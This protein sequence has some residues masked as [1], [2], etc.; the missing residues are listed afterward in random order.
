[1]VYC[2]LYSNWFLAPLTLY[3]KVVLYSILHCFKRFFTAGYQMQAFIFLACVLCKLQEDVIDFFAFLYWRK[4]WINTYW[5]YEVS[6]EWL[7]FIFGFCVDLVFLTTRVFHLNI[8]SNRLR[9]KLTW[10]TGRYF[11]VILCIRWHKIF[12]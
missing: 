3:P 8:T 9:I 10:N 5:L 7:L 1:M 11:T 2:L 4:F 6:N 12:C